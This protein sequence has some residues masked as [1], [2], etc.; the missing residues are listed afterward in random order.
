MNWSRILILDRMNFK[1]IDSHYFRAKLIDQ[2]NTSNHHRTDVNGVW[3]WIFEWAIVN[4][5]LIEFLGV[6][7]WSL[8][9]QHSHLFYD[10]FLV[11][12]NQRVFLVVCIDNLN[13]ILIQA[14]WSDSHTKIPFQI[15]TKTQFLT[16]CTVFY[17]L[18]LP[19]KNQI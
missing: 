1:I 15:C 10:D 12:I 18:S 5:K 19:N 4:C 11:I 8:E 3:M 9:L 16:M 13:H 14:D 6:G 17:S 7:I 2:N